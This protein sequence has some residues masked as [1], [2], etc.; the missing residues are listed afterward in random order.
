MN[1]IQ[2]QDMEEQLPQIKLW[3]GQRVVTFKDID[4][5]HQ[6]KAGTA[7]KNFSNNRK[8]FIEDVDYFIVTKEKVN[9]QDLSN[10]KNF[11][12]ENIPPKGITVFTESGYLM[13]VKSFKDDLSWEVQRRLVNSY[14]QKQE[15]STQGIEQVAEATITLR[16]KLS[17]MADMEENFKFLCEAY[18]FNR[19]TLYHHILV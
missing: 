12:I 10:G 7:K 1:Q 17:W 16:R 2:T 14:F 13:I 8:Y 6:R 18:N 4:E 9:E 11:H 19:K 3:N 5:V 15:Q